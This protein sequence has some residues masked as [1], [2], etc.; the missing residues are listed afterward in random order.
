MIVFVYMAHSI[1]HQSYNYLHRESRETLKYVSTSDAL[2]PSS[3]N[4][5]Q[6]QIP[7]WFS[8]L[9]KRSQTMGVGGGNNMQFNQIHKRQDHTIH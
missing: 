7:A 5:I 2:D 4:R 1:A 3:S 9:W 6:P 8:P